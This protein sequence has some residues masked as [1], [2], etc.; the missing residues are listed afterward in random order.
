MYAMD[1]GTPDMTKAILSVGAI[2]AAAVAL[3]GCGGSGS[4]SGGSAS[5]TVTTPAGTTS[6]VAG[7]STTKTSTTIYGSSSN[8]SNFN[9]TA[10]GLAAKIQQSVKQFANGNLAGAASSG[11][12]L[13]R[14][15]NSTVNRQ[16]APHAIS[17][18]QREATKDLR[19]ACADMKK[20]DKQ[21]M[22]GNLSG[23]KTS[24]L[25]AAHEAR[26]AARDIR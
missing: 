7:V 14:S 4:A 2:L 18:M 6:G 22:S 9:A 16:L 19:L 8:G 3:A 17:A 12:S 10:S 1:G 26:L 23:A 15:C 24:A 5:G 13:L 25:Q 21:G 20:A 11:A